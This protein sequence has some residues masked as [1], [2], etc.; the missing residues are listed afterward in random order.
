MIRDGAHAF[1]RSSR[2][3]VS[4][5]GARW[6]TQNTVSNPAGVVVKVV[7]WMPALLTSTSMRGYFASRTRAAART[8]SR[9]RKSA[10]TNSTRTPWF[11]TSSSRI[12]SA[13]V[14]L[15]HTMTMSAPP[16]AR[17]RAAESPT[18]EVEPA[19]MQT[20]PCID[21]LVVF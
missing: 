16:R 9:S 14:A 13:L 21:A 18:P 5:K 12:G 1:I 2:R 10:T 11:P 7:E 17:R 3:W 20:L 19:T 6:L 15:R 4:R 8:E